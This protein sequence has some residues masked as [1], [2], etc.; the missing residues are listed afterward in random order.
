MDG[1]RAAFRE[2]V[3][4]FIDDGSLAVAIMLTVA[5]SALLLPM[6]PLSATERSLLFLAALLAV[7]VE[8]ICRTGRRQ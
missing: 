3:G 6:L 2:F 1:L 8:N 5:A 7:L 4:L